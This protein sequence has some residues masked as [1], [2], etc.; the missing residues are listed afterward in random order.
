M[1][2][3]LMF[4][5]IKVAKSSSFKTALLVKTLWWAEDSCRRIN[6]LV[7]HLLMRLLILL[8]LVLMKFS[9]LFLKVF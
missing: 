4:V 9:A 5:A 3:K 7:V 6:Y 1:V 8:P 2:V